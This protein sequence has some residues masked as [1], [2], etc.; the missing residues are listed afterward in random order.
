MEHVIKNHVFI[1]TSII[2]GLFLMVITNSAWLSDDSFISLTQIINF[3]NGDG[4][5]FNFDER[6]QAFTHPSWFFLLSFVTY[7]TEDYYYTIL[8]ISMIFSFAAVILAFYFAKLQGR[9][10]SAIVPML[11]LLFSKAFVDYTTSGLENPLSYFLFGVILTILLAKDILTTKYLII[12]YIIM[13]LLFL[14]RMDYALILFPP[15][16]YLLFKY[17]KGNI[18]AL[19]LASIMVITWFLFALFYFGHI[20]PN[21]YYA[22][23]VAGYSV[24]EYWEKGWNYYVI[25]FNRDPITLVVIITGILLGLLKKGLPQAFAIGLVLYLL[26]FFKSGGDF[27]QGRFFATPAYIATFLMINYFV[28]IKP[29]ILGYYILAMIIVII[30]GS[31]SSSPVFVGKEYKNPKISLGVGDE[32]GFYFQIYGL[33][34][35]NRKWPE[36]VK[37]NKDRPPKAIVTCGGVGR[38]ALSLR[39]QIFIIDNCALTS[40]LLSQIPASQEPWRIGHQVRKLPTNYLFTVVD[41]NISLGDIQLNNLYQD[42]RNVTT[43]D[44]FSKDRLNSIYKI[45]TYSYDINYSMYEN[46]HFGLKISTVDFLENKLEKKY[47][48][49]RKSITID[50]ISYTINEGMEWNNLV[51]HRM[52]KEG[53]EIVFDQKVYMKN[54][55]I[56]LDSNDAYLIRFKNNQETIKIL[57]VPMNYIKGGGMRTRYIKLKQPILVN[58]MEVIPFLGDARYSLGY[59]NYE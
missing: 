6:V 27:M 26:Y 35:E 56:G 10:F 30:T 21:T 51:C 2:L 3:Q 59:L 1:I 46:P 47:L 7:I 34:S 52:D 11:L 5:V 14:N 22:K 19:T 36:I 28:K 16:L 58:T 38:K 33:T 43:G 20:F 17:K 25:Q 39:N 48:K 54:I 29:K 12:I 41:N 40:P 23:L 32:R 50:K 13:A 55:K 45:N 42:I 18:S 24:Y 44:I 53:L 4:I 15:V 9:L 8:A 31:N 57:E 49:P 37:F